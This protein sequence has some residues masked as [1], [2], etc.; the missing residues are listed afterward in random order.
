MP[1]IHKGLINITVANTLR[2][3]GGRGGKCWI[4]GLSGI[5][6]SHGITG[7]LRMEITWIISDNASKKLISFKYGFCKIT[8]RNI[9]PT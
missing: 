1:L 4:Y 9:A 6:Q 3:F 7:V 5:A 8:A 2:N